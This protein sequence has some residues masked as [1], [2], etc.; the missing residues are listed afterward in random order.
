MFSILATLLVTQQ[1]F[2]VTS[3]GAK[4]DGATDDTAA[5]RKATAALAQAGGG[6]LL[7]PPSKTYF[8]GAF[9]L[10]DEMVRPE[11][12]LFARQPIRYAPRVSFPEGA[13]N[14]PPSPLLQMHFVI[15]CL[16]TAAL[17]GAGRPGTEGAVGGERERCT[18]GHS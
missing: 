6:T 7:F 3:Y 16:P 2:D 18:R 10:S 13:R 15:L 4:G 14:H 11:G 1:V 9:N 17:N 12:R 5:I 8:T